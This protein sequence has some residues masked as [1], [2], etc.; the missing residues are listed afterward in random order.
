MKT[1]IMGYVVLYGIAALTLGLVGFIDPDR[2]SQ[3]DNSQLTTK[4]KTSAYTQAL[5]RFSSCL[6]TGL[7]LSC[8]YVLLNMK[9][10]KLL[11][12]NGFI[13]SAMALIFHG[14]ACYYKKS[15]PGYVG[16]GLHLSYLGYHVFFMVAWALVIL[17]TTSE[18]KPGKEKK[19]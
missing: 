10:V 8:F 14:S 1:V 9:F 5:T 2:I 6:V 18:S 19:V 4:V 15:V 3:L 17:G 11:A 16:D 13:V 12:F 7:A